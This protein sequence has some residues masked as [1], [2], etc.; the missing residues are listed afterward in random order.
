[1]WPNLDWDWTKPNLDRA[2]RLQSYSSL[3]FG[4]IRHRLKLNELSRQGNTGRSSKQLLF[5]LTDWHVSK[6]L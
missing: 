1:M 5:S 6:F 3:G 2:K 4:L